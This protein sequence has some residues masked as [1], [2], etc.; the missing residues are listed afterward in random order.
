MV[1][2]KQYVLQKIVDGEPITVVKNGKIDVEATRKSGLTAH[3]LAFKLRSQGVYSIK[4]LKEQ[5]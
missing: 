4:K 5:C 2:N 3:D 1:E